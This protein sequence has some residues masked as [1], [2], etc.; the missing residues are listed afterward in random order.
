M[1]TFFDPG[2]LT[3]GDLRLVLRERRPAEP[4]HGAVLESVPE[5]AFDITLAGTGLRVAS[6]SLRLGSSQYF[7]NHVGHLGFAVDPEHRG[8]HYAARACQLLFPLARKHRVSPLRL[9]CVPENTASRRTIEGLGGVLEELV[10]VPKD[11]ELYRMGE[12]LNCRYR[13]DLW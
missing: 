13:L 4:A 2:E 12:R 6:T 8:H 5:Y 3:D 9:V 11:G 10:P 1:P 7:L